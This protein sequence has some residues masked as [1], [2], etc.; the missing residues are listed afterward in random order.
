M[1]LIDLNRFYPLVYIILHYLSIHQILVCEQVS[2]Q[3]STVSVEFTPTI[4]HCSMAT[5]IGLSIKVKLLRSLPDRFKVNRRF[6]KMK[7]D[8][9]DLLFSFRAFDLGIFFY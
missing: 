7:I 1:H 8:L 9:L 6:F 4:P 3:E 5:L 2:D